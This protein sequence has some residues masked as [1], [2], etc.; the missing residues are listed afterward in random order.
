MAFPTA[1]EWN[2]IMRSFAEEVYF[3]FQLSERFVQKNKYFRKNNKK[4]V[5]LAG[6]NPHVA[7]YFQ[8]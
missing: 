1:T 6:P 8:T 5:L 3:F 2:I 4:Y 7:V